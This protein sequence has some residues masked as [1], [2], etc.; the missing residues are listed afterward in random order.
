[1]AKLDKVKVRPELINEEWAKK[2]EMNIAND[3]DFLNVVWTFFAV[4]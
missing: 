3:C 2:M 4:E 1:M